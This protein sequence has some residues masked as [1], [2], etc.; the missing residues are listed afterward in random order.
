MPST[1]RGRDTTGART[2][3]TALVALL[4]LGLVGVAFGDVGA[5]GDNLTKKEYLK[6][7]NALCADANQQIAAGFEQGFGSSGPDSQPTPEQ[8]DAA[9]T[10]LVTISRQV[11]D[12]LEAL[13]GPNS[14]EKKVHKVIHKLRG[15]VDDVE[16]DPQ[17]FFSS[18]ADPFAKADKQARK[19]GLKQC[20]AES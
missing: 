5:A 12:D 2:W 14:F 20:G 3:R 11:L 6:Q 19:L 1:M 4:T 7:A 8:V 17:G 15:V 9:V 18:E 10:N 13:Q 16:A